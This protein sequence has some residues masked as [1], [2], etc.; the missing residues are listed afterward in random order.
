M[1]A[2]FKSGGKQYKAA[3]GDQVRVERIPGG[4]GGEVAFDR[5]L[6]ASDGERVEIGNPFLEGARVVGR[7]QRHDKRPKITVFK[8]KRRKGYRRTR[9]HRQPYT[10]VRIEDVVVDR[11]EG[12]VI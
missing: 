1:Y 12:E 10:L 3:A 6:L 5:V 9:G 7:I 4:V 8:F 11:K 2:V